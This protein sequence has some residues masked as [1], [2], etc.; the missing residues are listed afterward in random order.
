MDR[1]AFLKRSGIATGGLA[2]LTGM[3]FAT[4][5][6]AAAGEIPHPDRSRPV[7]I[8][9]NFCTH[10]SVGCT[11]RAEVQNG[12]WVAQEPGWDSPINRG[13]HCAKGAATRELVMGE[14]RLR[15]PVKLID[16]QWQRISWDQAIE[17]ISKK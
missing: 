14:R 13:T 11:V 8:R 7:T 12:I 10:C 15:Y 1:R 9:K 4:V 6:R 5:Q 17:E 2:A 16:G 3:P